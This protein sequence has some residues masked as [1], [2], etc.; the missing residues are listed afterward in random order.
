MAAIDPNAE[1]IGNVQPVGLVLAAT[2]LA[3]QGLNPAEQTRADSEAVRALLSANDEGPALPDPWTFFTQILGWRPKQVAGAPGGPPLPEEL[4]VRVE[5]CETDLRPH[6]AVTDPDRGWQILV[7][8]EGA[9]VDPEQRGALKGW[10]ATPHQQLERLLRETGAATGLLVTDREL[11]LIHAP[12]GET[13]GWLKFPI[14]SLCEVGGRPMLG[15]LKLILS[16]VRLH[17]DAPDRRLASLLKASRDAQAEV[18]TRLAA[19]VLGA[20]FE[21]LRGLHSA[22]R[23]RTEALAASQPEHLYEGLLTV[24]LRLVFLLYAEDRDL[25]PSRSDGEALALYDRGYGVRSLYTHLLD[26]AA[27]HPDTMD[28]RRG[29]WSRLL[30]LFRLMHRGDPTGWIRGRGGKLFD[31]EAFPFLQGQDNR[32]DQPSPA[33]V[34][35]GCILRVLDLL[36]SLDGEKLSY[37]TLDVEQIGSVYETVIGFTVETRPGPALAIRAG[38]NDR[39]PVFVDLAA[40][41]AKKGSERAKFLKEEA[42][43]GSL[44]DRVGKALAAATDQAAII[45]ALRPIVDERASPG[46]NLAAAGTP[47][48]QPTDERRRTGSYY[49]PRSLTGPIVKHALEPAFARLG[50][51]AGPEAVLD[52]KV[53]DPAMG[54]GAFLVEACRVLGGRLAQA[55]ARWPK[56]RPTIPPDEDEHLHARRLVAQRCLYGV[57]RNP[58]AVDL[59][60]LSLWLATLARDHEFTFL[61]HALK[62]GDSLVGL[63]TTQIAAT[64]WDTSKPPTFVGK[65]VADH[66]KAAEEARAQIRDHADEATEA[67]LRPM[68]KA[69]DAKLEVAR[70][71]GDGVISA[72]FHADKPKE[73]IKRLV[74]FQKAVQNHLGSND[75]VKAVGP[76]GS[77]L[78][79]GAHP[80]PPFHWQVEFPE[81]FARKNGGFDAIVGNP[82]FAGKNTVIAG[83]RKN[84]LPWLQTL[85][86]GAHGNADLVAHFF[87][88]AFS[89]LRGGGIFGLIA[90]NT[91]GQGDT[92][93]SGLATI[94][95]EGGAI[96]RAARRLK[97]PGEAAVVV[98]VV[99]VSKGAVT[100]PVLDRQPVR[101]I[102]AYL[103]EGDLDTSPSV[104]AANS[105]KAFV[106]SYV[107]GVGFT[108]DDVAAAKGEAETLA[109][110]H[111]LLEKDPRNAQRVFPYIG[112]EEVNNDPAHRHRRYVIDFSDFPLRREQMQNSWALM[113]QEQRDECLRA[114]TVPH[115]YP[116]PVVAD[117]PDLL[118]I[119]ERR[120]KPQ[121]AR[122]KREVY[123]RRW[124]IYAERRPALYPALVPLERVLVRSL[125]SSHFPCFAY[126]AKGFVYDQTLIVW[127]IEARAA[128]SVLSS[129]IHEVW[130]LFLGATLEDRGRYNIADCFRTFPFPEGFETDA[131]LEAAGEAYHTFRAQLMINRNEGLTKTYN[132]FHSRGENGADIA[133]LRELH[134]DLDRA[135]LRAYG[136]DSLAA[137]AAAE[138]IE[139]EADEGKKPKTR[140][141]WPTD[142]KDEVLSKL[143]A[144][145]TQRAAAERA[146]GIASIPEDEDEEIDQE[147]GA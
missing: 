144:L 68:L 10:E 76:F 123:R 84:Y 136:W 116:G 1:W 125:T 78:K 55:W 19:Q 17:N 120:V 146:A 75:W 129:R 73:R 51:D 71:I 28:E 30:A 57:D 36:L 20:L 101:R 106:G 49:T 95:A 142:F 58:R 130:A 21:L 86:Q 135:V 45:A 38:K 118:N 13:S 4:A 40:L 121:R 50:P 52:L 102:S 127:P 88:R 61:D 42:D 79:I 99:H 29:A 109:T 85:H 77:T 47:L 103:V 87:R 7:R 114:G 140:L 64:H 66:L 90:T 16:S 14:R 41:T 139:E 18:S 113:L 141:D 39:T 122:D 54:S 22:D 72:F 126:L 32:S 128:Y 105:G 31:P 65:L 67:E 26:D 83:H 9:G 133:R 12:R 119:V 98:S 23:A 11:R 91:I 3:R 35:D 5:E 104:L 27:H 69:V 134:A 53:C 137:R 6:W 43:R 37:R 48:L 44:S 131:T 34:S 74:E 2:V 82:P 60:R 112:G 132:C 138:F 111:A 80:I 15:G 107:L 124:W 56:T 143:L 46:G 93:A 59:A 70:L 92:R 145:N 89:L 96:Q 33:T 97:W 94:L 100:Q 108:F 24:L 147:V 62:C 115:D 81:V 63:T 8:L 25:I 110:M 117:W